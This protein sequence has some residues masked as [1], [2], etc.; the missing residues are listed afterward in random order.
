MIVTFVAAHCTDACPLI[1]AQFSQIAQSLEHDRLAGR[2]LTITLD[3]E[4]DFAQTMREL[5]QRFDADP[6]AL[7]GGRR[8]AHDVHDV[9]RAF[10]VISVQGEHGYRDEHTTF[11]YVFNSHGELAQTMLASTA[12]QRRRRR[13]ACATG[14]GRMH[15]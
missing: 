9:M 2:L 10:G 4:H 15:A 6:R 3:P 13:R 5:A 14:V 8:F 11:V 12:P 7:A 1:N